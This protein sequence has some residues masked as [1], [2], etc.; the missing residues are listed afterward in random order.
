MSMK[1]DPVFHIK[2]MLLLNVHIEQVREP[3]T[4]ISS[5]RISIRQ[6]QKLQNSSSVG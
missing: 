6:L 2:G 1:F 3:E 4:Q 5:L